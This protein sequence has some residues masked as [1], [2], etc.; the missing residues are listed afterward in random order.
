MH[1]VRIAICAG[2][3]AVSLAI[4]ATPASAAETAHYACLSKDAQREALS[5]GKAVPLAQAI[6]TIRPKAKSEVVR[7]RLCRSPSGL[8][9]LLTLLSRSGKVTSATVDAANGN[10]IG[11]G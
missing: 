5:A 11:G 10:V 3:F 7:A 4:A 1:H 6:R 9:Y 8:V 2:W